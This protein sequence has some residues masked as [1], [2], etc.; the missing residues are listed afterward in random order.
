[1]LPS[2]L[3]VPLVLLLLSLPYYSFAQSEFGGYE[4]FPPNNSFYPKSPPFY[5]TPNT[6]GLGWDL[7]YQKAKLFLE[8]L[9]LE[10][11]AKL[12]TGSYTDTDNK[13]VSILLLFFVVETIVAKVLGIVCDDRSPCIGSIDPIPRV[14]FGG[15]CFSDSDL[16]IGNQHKC[17]NHK[18][19]DFPTDLTDNLIDTPPVSPRESPSLQLGT[20]T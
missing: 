12:V 10:E 7:A 16:G 20:K 9:T 13:F 19:R 6:T 1:M 4:L 2:Q 8:T 5:P 17:V 14:G 15:L 3:R 18:N 11:K